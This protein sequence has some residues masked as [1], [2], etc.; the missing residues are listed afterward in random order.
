MGMR[1]LYNSGLP[2]GVAHLSIPAF[3]LLAT[4][5]FL[6]GAGGNGGLT[7]SVNSTAKTFPDKAVSLG[8]TS[9]LIS[10]DDAEG[11]YDRPRHLRLRPICLLLFKH[12]TSILSW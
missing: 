3:L 12:R 5:S 8:S 1:Y 6:T 9:V 7:G 10:N 4:C 11:I 2:S